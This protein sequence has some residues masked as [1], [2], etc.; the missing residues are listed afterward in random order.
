MGLL[1]HILNTDEL[2]DVYIYKGTYLD[3]TDKLNWQITVNIVLIFTF[4]VSNLKNFVNKIISCAV[5]IYFSDN[6]EEYANQVCFISNKYF[7]DDNERV[8]ISQNFTPEPIGFNNKLLSENGRK[9]P[10]VVISYYIWVPYILLI[11]A[12]LF[13]AVKYL[14]LYLFKILTNL[15]IKEIC[16][17]AEMCKNLKELV[18]ID[19]GKMEISKEF[20]DNPHLN[21]L[22]TELNKLIYP[23]RSK[24]NFMEK[25]ASEK[26]CLAY[27]FIKFLNLINIL[28]QLILIRIFLQTDLY[29]LILKPTTQFFFDLYPK[30]WKNN[31]E[32]NNALLDAKSA[33]LPSSIY[34][35]LKSMCIFR[36]R[37]LA[38]TNSYAVMCS[39]PINLF[40]QYMFIFFSIWYILLL[41]LNVYHCIN[42]LKMFTFKNQLDHLRKKMSKALIS[43]RLRDKVGKN[44]NSL[45]HLKENKNNLSKNKCHCEEN[46]LDFFDKYLSYD[47]IFVL[48][49]ISIVEDNNFDTLIKWEE[50]VPNVDVEKR[51][52]IEP[53]STIIQKFRLKWF[54]HICR[55][56]RDRIP[57][58]AMFEWEPNDNEIG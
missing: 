5:P 22:I 34:F 2:N 56:E 44:C 6:Q 47:F 3:I 38:K 27:L 12:L 1:S 36:I 35:P 15:D 31:I 19:K 21:Y 39:L 4:L 8:I 11:Q 52:R 24:N 58:Q 55:M 42:W 10:P 41:V 16:K 50:R 51:S 48:R 20:Q 29:S 7:V 54:G 9:E 25:I 14:W 49:I 57:K 13:V 37:E 40:I 28:I 18:F 53:V 26:L 45:Y 17:S 46:L 43:F 33:Y 23:I 32:E 30:L